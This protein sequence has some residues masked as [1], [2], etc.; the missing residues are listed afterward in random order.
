MFLYLSYPFLF[1]SIV[2]LAISMLIEDGSEKTMINLKRL[3]DALKDALENMPDENNL[4]GEDN[5]RL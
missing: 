2:I 4:K 3:N 1:V 5:E